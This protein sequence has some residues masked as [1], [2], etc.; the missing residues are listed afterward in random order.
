M[1]GDAGGERD[2]GEREMR[3]R[4]GGGVRMELL[5]VRRDRQ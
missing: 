5:E 4:M 2:C 3:K 1:R